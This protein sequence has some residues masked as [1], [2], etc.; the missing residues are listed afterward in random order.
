VESAIE[1]VGSGAWVKDFV[2]FRKPD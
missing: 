1:R 2:V